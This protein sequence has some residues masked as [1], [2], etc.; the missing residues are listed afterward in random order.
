MYNS[1]SDDNLKSFVNIEELN[2]DYSNRCKSLSVLT[3]YF[4]KIATSKDL[5]K[6][7][8]LAA[9]VEKDLNNLDKFENQL[10]KSVEKKVINVKQNTSSRSILEKEL[11]DTNSKKEILINKL[12]EFEERIESSNVHC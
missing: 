12:Q 7:L 1:Q 3:Q 2:T 5:D 9:K 4:N 8:N 11:E 10:S 6:S